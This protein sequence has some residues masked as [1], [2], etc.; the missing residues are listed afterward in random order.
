M[1][2]ISEASGVVAVGELINIWSRG[3]LQNQLCGC[4]TAFLECTFWNDVSQVT[5]GTWSREVRAADYHRLQ[6]S[7]HGYWA[8]PSLWATAVRSRSYTRRLVEYAEVV[9]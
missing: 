1:R 2:A 6:Q 7:V 9:G 8:F 3:F 5:F 4:G